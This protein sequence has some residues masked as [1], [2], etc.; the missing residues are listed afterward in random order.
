MLPGTTKSLLRARVPCVMEKPESYPHSPPDSGVG[1]CACDLSLADELKEAISRGGVWGKVCSEYKDCSSAKASYPL[2]CPGCL[3][4]LSLSVV[5][6]PRAVAAV[7][8]RSVA[9]KDEGLGRGT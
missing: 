3:L 4:L 5:G 6:M 2:C 1:V 7:L 8:D 9:P